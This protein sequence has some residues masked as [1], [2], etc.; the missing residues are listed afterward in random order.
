[1]GALFVPGEYDAVIKEAGE[2]V[3]KNGNGM[4]ELILK[5]YDGGSES[6]QVYDY[7][8]ATDNQAWKWRHFCAS[9]GLVYERGELD[10]DALVNRNVRVKIGV[11]EYKGRK[12]N[13][14]EDYV[15]K[16]AAVAPPD[17]DI[18]F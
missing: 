13:V 17:N 15:A 11:E 18:P 2:G 1:M 14:V 9:A 7:L 6:G 4:I 3:S 8:V 5:A 16:P 12:K 10:A